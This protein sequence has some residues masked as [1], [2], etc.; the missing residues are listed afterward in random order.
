MELAVAALTWLALIG[1]GLVAGTFFAFSTFVMP[2]LGNRPPHEAMAAMREINVVVV[3]SGFIVV[4]VA[5][6]FASL[7]LTGIALLQWQVPRS[8]ALL[9]GAAL[10]GLGTFALTI[11]RNVPLND[12]LAAAPLGGEAETL[13]T[14]YLAEWTW[15]NSVRTAFAVGALVAFAISLSPIDA[16]LL[17]RC[18]NLFV[19]RS[20]A[21]AHDVSA[22][23]ERTELRQA[24]VAPTIVVIQNA[25]RT[26]LLRG[27]RF[28]IIDHVPKAPWRP[29]PICFGG[30]RTIFLAFFSPEKLHAFHDF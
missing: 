5:T 11:V 30:K 8:L 17:L 21:A 25:A 14:R 18:S 10:Y 27:N 22:A 1:S 29:Q 4:F 13:W 12:A 26:H 16:Q 2:A 6:A 20:L 3:R 15:W 24:S 23:N 28:L 19:S 7:A 9:A